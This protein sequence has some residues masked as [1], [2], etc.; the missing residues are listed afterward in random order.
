MVD[1]LAEHLQ[2]GG[3]ALAVG[4]AVV[5]PLQRGDPGVDGP[6]PARADAFFDDIGDRA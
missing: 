4:D 5:S 2:R 6:E 1:V 3:G